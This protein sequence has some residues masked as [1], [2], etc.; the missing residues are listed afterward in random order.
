M[1]DLEEEGYRLAW[2]KRSSSSGWRITIVKSRAA[3]L[4]CGKRTGTA[5]LLRATAIHA[6]YQLSWQGIEKEAWNRQ[7]RVGQWGISPRC[8]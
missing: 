3:S 4:P 1:Q 2:R 7:I 8:R 5:D 6:G